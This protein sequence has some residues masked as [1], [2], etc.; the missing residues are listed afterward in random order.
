MIHDDH[1]SMSN[2]CLNIVYLANV[3]YLKH[4]SSRGTNI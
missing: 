2:E 1:F 3:C 4:V